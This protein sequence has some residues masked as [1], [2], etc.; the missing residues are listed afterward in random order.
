MSGPPGRNLSMAEVHGS[1]QVPR[2]GNV[3]RRIF[4]VAG[5]A[6][7]VAVGYMDP[8]N[9][10][11][12][13]AAGSA[14]NTSLL[15]VLVMSNLMAL[16]LQSLSVRLGVVRG[17][18]LAQACRREYP[19]LVNGALWVLCEIAIAACDL[20]EV[21]GSAIALQL[22][23]GLPLAWGVVLTAADTLLLLVLGRYGIR[24]VEAFII[25]LVSIIAGG[26]LVEVLLVQPEWG[27]VATGLIPS[28]PGP[29]AL[30]V[31][32]GMLGATVMPHNLYL[33]SSLVQTRHIGPSPAEKRTAI[34][35]NVIDSAIALTMALLVNG[36]ILIVAASV[37]FRAGYHEITSIQEASHLLEPILGVAWAPVIFAV[38]LL[39]AGQSS[40]ITGTMAGQIVMEGFLNIRIPPWV[41]RLITRLLAVIPAVVVILVSGEESTG[42]LLVLSQVI[43]SAQ[44]PFAI[45]PLVHFVSD[46]AA[47]GQFAI[48]RIT[49][50]LAWLVTLIIV[51]LNGWLLVETLSGLSAGEGTMWI[52]ALVIPVAAALMALLLYVWLRPWVRRWWRK[53]QVAADV[54]I[55]AEGVVAAGLAGAVGTPYRNVA[56]ALDFSGRDAEVLREAVRFLGCNRPA[57]ALMHVVESAPAGF[58]GADSG[59][60]ESQQ[61]AARLE[62]WA[63]EFRTMGFEATTH[64]GSGRPVPELAR[65]IGETRADLVILAAH[66]HGFVKDVLLGSTADRLRH[67]VDAHVLVVAK[68]RAEEPA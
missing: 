65:M 9:W 53:R 31:A 48:G 1:V 12:D 25:G 13:L 64:L 41:R 57:V 29:G 14:F 59:D 66:G 8:G 18:D 35:F 44:L 54:G 33:H 56:I 67:R 60:A 17:L 22:L 30:Y 6:Y 37:F 39:A 50:V 20:A 40:T 24:K 10:A 61:D 45:I 36:A 28:L 16:L 46:R 49:R 63:A 11:T 23:F 27:S 15:W 43:L 2:Y 47:M 62:A 68:R 32:M 42:A 3:F 55:H 34:R 19:P 5:P 7:L 51:A 52:R 38:A 58:H 21:L 26:L 4:A